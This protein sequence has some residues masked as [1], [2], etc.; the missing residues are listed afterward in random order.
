MDQCPS[1]T[2]S[3]TSRGFE[4]TSKCPIVGT[5]KV[6]KCAIFTHRGCLPKLDKATEYVHHITATRPTDT[7]LEQRS[8]PSVTTQH[9]CGPTLNYTT[10]QLI[11]D[12][13]ANRHYS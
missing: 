12:K 9:L 5:S 2:L 3:A 11:N 10:I 8:H 1:S 7:A 4:N 13:I 6:L